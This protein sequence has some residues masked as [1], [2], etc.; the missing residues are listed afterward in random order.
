MSSSDM[1]KILQRLDE[2]VGG[3]V[4][5]GMDPNFSSKKN[6]ASN[7]D[8]VRAYSNKFRDLDIRGTPQDLD[9]WYNTMLF[10]VPRGYNS[11]D[12]TTVYKGFKSLEKN[13]GEQC[14]PL[15]MVPGREGSVV[16]YVRGLYPDI[17]LLKQQIEMYRSALGGPDE[18]D[19][20]TIDGQKYVRVWWD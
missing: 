16:L 11:Y 13:C 9:S 17:K 1:R 4:P 14:V 10:A 6:G 18:I 19:I 3:M 8:I 12:T 15:E 7:D 2:S 5:Q 20:D